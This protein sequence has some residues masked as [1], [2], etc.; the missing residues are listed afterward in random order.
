[1]CFSWNQ[2]VYRYNLILTSRGQEQDKKLKLISHH[3]E[4]IYDAMVKV[5]SIRCRVHIKTS[6]TSINTPVLLKLL[7]SLVL[8]IEI[9]KKR[10]RKINK[11]RHQIKGRKM[12]IRINE[13]SSLK[14]KKKELMKII[15]KSGTDSTVLW[16]TKKEEERGSKKLN[17]IRF[18]VAVEKGCKNTEYFRGKLKLHIWQSKINKLFCFHNIIVS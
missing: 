2:R 11:I 6:E 14:K 17:Q 7:L 5:S 8:S 1:M 12:L 15:R 13:I 9:Q 18:Q 4:E 3:V 16:Q 10:Q